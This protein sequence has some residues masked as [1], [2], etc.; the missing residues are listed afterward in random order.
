MKNFLFICLL[1]A[2]HLCFGQDLV[3]TNVSGPTSFDQYQSFSVS[4]TVKNDGIVPINK[5]VTNIGYLSKDNIL[6]QDD[7]LLFGGFYIDSLDAGES[8]TY[9]PMT[10]SLVYSISPG[11]YY[12]IIV[13]DAYSTV[14]ETNEANNV[15]AYSNYTIKNP[16]VDF[17]LSSLDVPPSTTS[18]DAI[19][20][21]F[22]IKN[23]GATDVG[24][25]VLAAFYI[26]KDMTLSSD[27]ILLLDL[28]HSPLLSGPDIVKNQSITQL[29][30]PNLS[31]GDYYIIGNV[32]D[33]GK[34]KGFYS[35]TNESNNSI[36]SKKVTITSSDIDLELKEI[37]RISYYENTFQ[38]KISIKNNGT[39]AVGTYGV[40]AYLSKNELYNDREV[41]IPVY[42]YYGLRLTSGETKS[43]S[44][45]FSHYTPGLYYLFFELNPDKSVT[46]T[47][48]S[49]NT[50]SKGYSIGIPLPPVPSWTITN[51]NVAGIFDNTDKEINIA[52][53]FL[54]SGTASY[55][56]ENYL[57]R[58]KNSDNAILHTSQLYQGFSL[59]VGSATVKNWVITLDNPLPVGQYTIEI[60]CANSFGCNTN[61]YSLPLVIV[62]AA[63]PLSGKVIGE[64][65]VPITK[66]K[67]FLYQKGENGLVKFINK[68]VPTV[69][70]QFQ[71]QLD[72]KEHTLFFIPDRI[73]F[74]KYAPTVY[75]KTVTLAPTSFFKLTSDANLTF[76]ILKIT[77]GA[78]GG[79]MINGVVTGETLSGGRVELSKNLESLPIVLLSENGKVVAVT[80]TDAAGKYQFANL[81][82][83]KYQ[84]V[85]A[86]EL[87]QMP[88][89]QPVAVDLTTANAKVDFNL[90]KE[91]ATWTNVPLL[92][93]GIEPPSSINIYPNPTS[94]MFS[95]GTEIPIDNIT[96]FDVIGKPLNINSELTNQVDLS[97]FPNGIYYLQIKFINLQEFKVFKVIKK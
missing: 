77:S 25:N 96:I 78:P 45:D 68:I 7:V 65:N 64:D 4:I 97:E 17:L 11:N 22:E 6:D 21:S 67:L 51:S 49:N 13:L 90:G 16:N 71:F 73:E 56:N 5:P 61:T 66:G 15:N 19:F 20:P 24:S 83:G 85:I 35:E 95:I 8:K 69:S 41:F 23:V 57:I 79:R 3:V 29:I 53:N 58:I 50:F 92:V 28:F 33:D 84:L 70:D 88:M 1:I 18:Y 9:L 86:L 59:F 39:T 82:T 74:E 10:Y 55:L 14:S 30:L 44:V 54:N 43:F 76:Q 72:D 89:T 32:D 48:Y 52:V 42:L 46:E 94:G 87:N 26:S 12:V 80:E 37:T 60:L 27:D 31:P 38:F 2:Q 62:P 81:A 91:G 34:G 75:G 47:N 40:E 36:V 63:Y 93:T